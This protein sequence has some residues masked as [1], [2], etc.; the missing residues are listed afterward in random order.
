MDPI[1]K[2]IY[3]NIP[4]T[5]LALSFS[6]GLDSSLLA[7]LA[8]MKGANVT[9]YTLS[10]HPQSEDLV[11]SR[12]FAKDLGFEL[13]EVTG[14]MKELM[15]AW[16]KITDR[17]RAEVMVGIELIVSKVKEPVVMFGTGSEEIFAGYDRHY[18]VDNIKQTLIYEF[19][20]IK[21]REVKYTELVC[22]KYGKLASLPFYDRHILEYVINNYDDKEILEDRQRK[23]GI[24]R[25]AASHL[26]PSYI[27]DRPKKALQYGSKINKLLSK[28]SLDSQ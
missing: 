12:R 18:Q 11:Y 20:M 15:K 28:F 17:V 19:E 7:V 24:L 14:N 4:A 23:K 5:D 27:I 2:M 9:L 26:L 10:L 8:R 16:L 1:L 22:N 21:N 25:K 3:D 13:V 6:G